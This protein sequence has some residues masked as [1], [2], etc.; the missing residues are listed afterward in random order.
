MKLKLDENLGR[1]GIE[2]CVAAGHDTATVL[3]QRLTS[4]PD[5]RVIEVCC[6]EG[7]LAPSQM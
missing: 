6:E 4:A 3:E 5:S 7:R 2:L 1:Q